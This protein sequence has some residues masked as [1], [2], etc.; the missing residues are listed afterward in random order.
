MLSPVWIAVLLSGG[1]LLLLFGVNVPH[2]YLSQP[3]KHITHIDDSHPNTGGVA[4]LVLYTYHETDEA[5]KNLDFFLKH[6]LHDKADFVFIMN[7]EYSI[8]IPDLPN[9]K[10]IDRP[11]T[12]Y[13]LGAYGEV[14][15][16]DDSLLA[17]K[18]SRFIMIN[19]SLRGPFFPSWANNCWSDTYLSKLSDR[20]KLVGMTYNCARGEGYLPH[21]QSMIMATDKLGMA[22][23]LPN[24]KCFENMG[25]AVA[26][27]ETQISRWIQEA[28]YGIYAMMSSFKAYGGEESEKVYLEACSGSDAL[29]SGNHNGTSLHPYDT[30]FSKTNRPWNEYDRKVIDQLTEYAHLS[31]YSS[32]DKC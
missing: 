8:S 32:Y 19:A 4:D 13:D 21:L 26:D 14:L 9:V 1:F 7:G 17:T 12:C 16:A 10:V 20:V 3:T 23:I 25:S 15:R 5:F 6:A 2:E 24:L 18:Y 31:G 22:A 29:Y 27:G 11:N 30:I 28:G